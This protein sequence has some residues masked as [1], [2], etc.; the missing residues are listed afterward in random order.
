[1]ALDKRCQETHGLTCELDGQ[2]VEVERNIE[3]TANLEFVI[4]KT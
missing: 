1:M 4:M 2:L 3:A